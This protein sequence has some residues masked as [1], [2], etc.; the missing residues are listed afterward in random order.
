MGVLDQVMGLRNRGV[1]DQ[2]IIR[3]LQEQGIPPVAINDAFSRAQ[4]K[5]AVNMRGTEGMQHSV[6]GSEEDID[7]ERLPVEGLEGGTLS[8]ID[9]TPP[10]PGGGYMGQ[11]QMPAESTREVADDSGEMY[12][13]Q[14][15][16]YPQQQYQQFQEYAPQAEQQYQQFQEYAPQA[17]YQYQNAGGMI[18]TDTMIEVSEQVFSEKNRPLQKKIEDMNEFRALAQTNID[19][20]SERLKKIEAIIDRL[21]ASILEKVGGYGQGIESVRKEMNMMQDSFSKMVNNIAEKSEHHQHHTNHQ[22]N[23]SQP[24]HHT[25]NRVT[26]HKSKKVTRKKYS[27]KR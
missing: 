12:E 6:M 24:Q 4:I 21:Q 13:P 1:S 20:I 26:V 11:Y 9:L 22:Q 14:E 15:A 23:Q 18:D 27:R 17:G 3:T 7:S 8:D 16:S 10:I 19:H 5:N 2:E 25:Q